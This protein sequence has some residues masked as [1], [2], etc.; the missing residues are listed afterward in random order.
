MLFLILDD[1]I[2][3]YSNILF[4]FERVTD[5]I[6]LDV[7]TSNSDAYSNVMSIKKNVMKI[8]RFV[9]AICDFL[10]RI[11]GRKISVISES[12]R[13]SLANLFSHT[14]MIVNEADAI[15]DILN[16]ILAQIDN[17]LMTRMNETMRILTAFA[18]IFLPMTLI[19]GIYGMNFHI[20]PEL[21]WDYGYYY[22]LGLMLAC[23]GTL[24]FIFK[25]FK[26][27]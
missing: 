2:N 4:H 11:S 6:D 19:A 15:R 27:F 12:C 22:A 5:Q 1:I 23:A 25:R 24:L 9:M 18:S 8:K 16:G 13:L 10:M 17:A 7:R 26:W 3:D 14:Q 20:M 21:E